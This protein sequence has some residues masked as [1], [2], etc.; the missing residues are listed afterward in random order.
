MLKRF[1]PLCCAATAAALLTLSP[2]QALANEAEEMAKEIRGEESY[3]SFP[4]LMMRQTG[5]YTLPDH[6]AKKFEQDLQASLG[7]WR[8]TIV[9]YGPNGPEIL[10]WCNKI[11]SDLQTYRQ[12]TDAETNEAELTL[13]AK[14]FQCSEAYS[15]VLNVTHKCRTTGTPGD[16]TQ[17]RRAICSVDAKIG[18]GKYNARFDA[19]AAVAGGDSSSSSLTGDDAPRAERGR[20]VWA[21][22]SDWGNEGSIVIHARDEQRMVIKPGEQDKAL[23]EA[24]EWALVTVL[25]KAAGLLNEQP[26]LKPKGMVQ[27]AKGSDVELCLSK[28]I[29]KL[30]APFLLYDEEGESVGFMKARELHDGCE[31]T[32]SI[33]RRVREKRKRRIA[34]RTRLKLDP[35]GKR[36]KKEDADID[37]SDWD[38][39]AMMAQLITGNATDR[40]GMG[41][42]AQEIPYSG[43]TFS[44]YGGAMIGFADGTAVGPGGGLGM[45]YSLASAL[46]I[47]E[48]HAYGQLGVAA[49][50]GNMDLNLEAGVL[51]RWYV[52][53]PFFIDAGAGLAAGYGLGAENVFAG[54]AANLGLG[55]TF[56]PGF[57]MRLKTG[58]RAGAAIGVGASGGTGFGHGALANLNF[59]FT[60]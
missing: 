48:L 16:A 4:Q 43:W 24:L 51:K 5:S 23:D 7:L 32:P 15:Y 45:E 17:T 60:M 21:P 13:E 10:D 57:G 18:F 40:F 53:G 6:I 25:S 28:D 42:L 14:A 47:S 44:L 19:N 27:D 55:L 12:E 39:G 8:Y 54:V 30:D 11:A 56:S 38:Q 1:A 29:V 59:N 2:S 37:D 31:L 20:M 35:L 34:T 36:G 33:E 41:Y 49:F 58:Y 52:A 50:S 3:R 26:D 46:D 22:E 9:D